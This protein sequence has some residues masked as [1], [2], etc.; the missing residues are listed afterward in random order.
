VK[1]NEYSVWSN[2]ATPNPCKLNLPNGLYNSSAVTPPPSASFKSSLSVIIGGA[3]TGPIGSRVNSP[4]SNFQ[5][6]SNSEILSPNAIFMKYQQPFNEALIKPGIQDETNELQPEVFYG[7]PVPKINKMNKFI[8]TNNPDGYYN[9]NTDMSMTSPNMNSFCY[10]G[11]GNTDL[12]SAKSLSYNS[13]G[14]QSQQMQHF[15]NPNHRVHTSHNHQQH[16]WVGRLPPK[17]F[18][19]NSIYS[20]KVFLGG[21]P[22][23][24]NQAYLIQLLQKYGSVK[25]EI[26]GKDQ[27]HPRVSNLSKGQERSTPGYVYIIFEHESAVQRMLCDCRKEIK[28]GG[29][30]YFYT[31]FIPSAHTNQ[32][33][34]GFY[35]F[36]HTMNKRGKAKEVE[37]IPW[38]QEDTSYVPQNK[39]A[40]LPAKI[41]SRTTIFVGAL[42]GMLNAHGLAKVMNEVFGEVIHAGLDTDKYKYP[43]GNFKVNFCIIII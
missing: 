16:T 14:A 34:N 24:V 11:S 21:L 36:N 3:S 41:D 26:P 8:K 4:S 39:T 32:N 30:H 37:V 13:N 23:D 33:S 43:I 31:I 35:S 42:H 5:L 12:N 7:S 20:R 25:L 1:Q 18:H 40:M 28:N 19:D 2:G 27:K 38:N 17:V 22:W 15:H 10:Q 29:E 9:S 6:T